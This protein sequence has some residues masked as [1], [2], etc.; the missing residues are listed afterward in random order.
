MHHAR[1]LLDRQVVA[2]DSGKRWNDTI[3]PNVGEVITF[4][5]LARGRPVGVLDILLVAV[6][7]ADPKITNDEINV[8]ARS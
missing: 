4:A 8:C 5:A 1:A 7:M 2:F 3:I 6:C